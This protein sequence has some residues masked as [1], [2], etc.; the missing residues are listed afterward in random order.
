M[1]LCDVYMLAPTKDGQF[2]TLGKLAREAEGV[3]E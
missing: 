1:A 2:E 3:N